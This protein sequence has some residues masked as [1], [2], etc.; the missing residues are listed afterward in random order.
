MQYRVKLYYANDVERY[1]IILLTHIQPVLSYVALAREEYSWATAE[2][3]PSF[4][5]SQGATALTGGNWSP[6]SPNPL[7]QVPTIVAMA[8]SIGL[9]RPAGNAI[10]SLARLFHVSRYPLQTGD[11]G[12]VEF[13]LTGVG[14]TPRSPVDITGMIWRVLGTTS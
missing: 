14:V 11:M 7:N 5:H 2:I 8:Q 1:A 9:F 6:P 4:G 3:K 13:G 10:V 12:P